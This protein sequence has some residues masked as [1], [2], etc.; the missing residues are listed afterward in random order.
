MGREFGNRHCCIHIEMCKSIKRKKENYDDENLISFQIQAKSQNKVLC[1][2][3]SRIDLRTV[4][5]TI[6]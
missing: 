4:S 2:E 5:R 3:P 6:E 1:Y